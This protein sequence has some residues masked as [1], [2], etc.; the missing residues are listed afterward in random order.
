MNYSKENLLTTNEM[1]KR[2]GGV[3]ETRQYPFC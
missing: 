2:G 1:G 3:L